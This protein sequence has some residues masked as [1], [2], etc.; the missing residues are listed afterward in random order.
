MEPAPTGQDSGVETEC[1]L[2]S[3]DSSIS[4]VSIVVSAAATVPTNDIN[5]ANINSDAVP[6]TSATS[7]SSTANTFPVPSNPAPISLSTSE[8]SPLSPVNAAMPSSSGLVP[9]SS[10]TED[11]YLGD[12]SSDGGNEKNFPMPPEKL[13]RLLNQKD[14]SEGTIDPPAGLAFQNL[15][16]SFQNNGYQIGPLRGVGGSG[17]KM[18]SLIKSRVHQHSNHNNWSHMKANIAG[19]KLRLAANMNNVEA[20]ERLLS[21]GANPNHVDE[22]Q[23]TALHFSSA[24]GYTEVARLLLDH[25]A[26]PNQKDALGNTALHLAACTNHVDVV[27][28]LLRAGT[29][30][31][32][33]DNNG[34]TPMQL[35]QSKLKLLQKGKTG[36]NEMTMVS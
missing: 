1:D 18:R 15:Q 6:S 26:D 3:N 7:N 22:H 33:L 35:A 27:T 20:V 29:N 9:P 11:G 14:P 21:S 32:E 28:L 24:K 19:R 16:P 5:D 36:T 2:E 8:A 23:R 31:T 34:R 25:G 17:R 4:N 30:V 12:C 13:K 10:V